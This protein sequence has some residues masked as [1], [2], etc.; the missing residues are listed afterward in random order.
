MTTITKTPAVATLSVTLKLQAANESAVTGDQ[1]AREAAILADE[2]DYTSMTDCAKRIEAILSLY[3]AELKHDSVKKIFSASLAVLVADKPVRIAATAQTT[4]ATTEKVKLTAPEAMAPVAEKGEVTPD[5]KAIYT[6]T[7]SEAVAK[8]TGD[9]LKLAATAAREALGIAR[10]VTTKAD[11]RTVR[12]PF[13]DEFAAVLGDDALRQQAFRMVDL[14]GKWHVVAGP[15]PKLKL[16]ENG[17]A[18]TLAA[19]AA[20]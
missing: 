5:K 10:K 14:T 17:K 8:L 16:A 12:A 9:T 15:A 1:F 18:P 13:F 3:M 11:K 6:F 4:S 19:Q 20:K 7:P 2:N